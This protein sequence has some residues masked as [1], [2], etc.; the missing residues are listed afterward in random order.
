MSGFW[1]WL[2][3]HLKNPSI[4]HLNNRF[5]DTHRKFQIGDAV[6]KISGSDWCGN[7]VGWY[8]TTTTPEGYAVESHWHRGSVQIYPASA[9]R[10][11]A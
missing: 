7:V 6:K 10:K 2:A 11:S 3:D 5:P 1:M 8:S 9:L 4:D